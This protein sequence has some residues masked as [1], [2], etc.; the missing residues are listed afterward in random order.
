MTLASGSRASATTCHGRRPSRR[1]PTRAVVRGSWVSPVMATSSSGWLHRPIAASHWGNAA[2]HPT[3]F[4]QWL[5]AISRWSQ[6]LDEVAI[7]GDTHDPR[8][9]ALVG[10]LRDGLRPWQLVALAL[11]PDASVIPLLHGR[12]GRAEPTAWVCHGGTCRLPVTDPAALRDQL[13]ARA[14]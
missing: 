4:P 11:E 5:A 10:V 14:A 3:A 13:R 9:T 6:P 12:G 1:T 7:T 2:E 8:T